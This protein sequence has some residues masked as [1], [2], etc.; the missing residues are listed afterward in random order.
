[1]GMSPP[2]GSHT[3]GCIIKAA[4]ARPS[5]SP[6]ATRRCSTSS[7]PRNSTPSSSIR[8]GSSTSRSRLGSTL[9]DR[10]WPSTTTLLAGTG[11][12]PSEWCRSEEHTSELQS[13]ENLV[14]RLLHEKIN[15][16][17]ILQLDL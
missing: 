9:P 4:D 3:H 7:T 5:T 6:P 17:R 8:G 15:S 13:R 10:R 12:A 2:T 14:C 16:K 11:S 1:P